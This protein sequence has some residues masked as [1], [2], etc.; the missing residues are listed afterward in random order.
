MNAADFFCQDLAVANHFLFVG[1]F[2]VHHFACFEENLV[3]FAFRSDVG[4]LFLVV[5]FDFV[6]M[7]FV[8]YFVLCDY[9]FDKFLLFVLFVFHFEYVVVAAAVHL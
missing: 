1:P 2:A 3:L 4:C 6:V 7:N 9:H 8:E 5:V